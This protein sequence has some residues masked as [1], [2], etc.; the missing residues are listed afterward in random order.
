MPRSDDDRR[1]KYQRIADPLREGIQAGKY[2]GRRSLRRGFAGRSWKRPVS[3]C[4]SS[5]Q[6]VSK[7]AVLGVVALVLPVS[8]RRR[9]RPALG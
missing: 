7:N 9:P 8:A 6:P 4:T 2:Q 1:P 5:A 3:R